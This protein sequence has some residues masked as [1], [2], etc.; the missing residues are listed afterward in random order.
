[1]PLTE[2]RASSMLCRLAIVLLASLPLSAPV[3]GAG[4]R[5]HVSVDLVGLGFANPNLSYEHRVSN[6]FSLAADL[7][8]NA[9]ALSDGVV[10]TPRVNYSPLGALRTGLQGQLGA[11]LPTEGELQAELGVGYAYWVDRMQ[12]TPVAR[13]RS[14]Q[15]FQLR[16]DVGYGWY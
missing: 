9:L 7:S 12:V 15:S 3:W 4:F 5:H 13:V 16:L 11:Y 10:L 6:H 8:T 14:D 1:M 2:I